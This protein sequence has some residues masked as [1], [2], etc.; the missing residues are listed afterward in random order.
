MDYPKDSSVVLEINGTTLPPA[1]ANGFRYKASVNGT[2]AWWTIRIN[3]KFYIE[4]FQPRFR[5]KSVLVA[6]NGTTCKIS[7]RYAAVI[8][9]GG[10]PDN[11]KVIAGH[12]GS[13]TTT[14]VMPAGTTLKTYSRGTLTEE[15]GQ[16]IEDGTYTGPPVDTYA[17]GDTVPN[18]LIEPPTNQF[19]R[20]KSIVVSK[21][22]Y[23]ST[24]IKSGM[25]TVHLAT[26]TS[27][28]PVTP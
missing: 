18:Y 27:D 3:G 4:V 1:K 26:C 23:L 6:S 10:R 9:P 25:G 5:P 28:C 16:S 19:N 11:E 22:T 20:E 17:P 15:N 24:L 13:F 7:I 8:E 12:G 2:V 14:F 21:P